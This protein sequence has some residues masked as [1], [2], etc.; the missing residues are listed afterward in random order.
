MAE[1]F[2]TWDPGI[3]EYLIE[4]GADVETGK[5]LA[6]ALSN[7]VRTALRIFKRY[8]DR[9]PS[10]QEQANIALRHHCKEG[11][12]KWVSLMLLAGADPYAPGTD[13][14][15]QKSGPPSESELSA[16]GYAALYGH[17]EVFDL[18]NVALDVKHPALQRIMHYANHAEVA[19]VVKRLFAMG[20][21][22]NDQENGGCSAIQSLL[23][24]MSWTFSLWPRLEH[25]PGRADTRESRQKMKAIH[26]LAKHGARWV[27]KDK[28][29]VSR[30]RRSLLKLKPDY[31]VEFVW[32]MSKYKACALDTIEE[33]L[34]PSSSLRPHLSH[35][36]QRI[37]ELLASWS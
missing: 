7:R 11:N 12:M 28:R 5:P 15:S 3:M 6:R 27:P 25:E 33:L 10:F 9:F 1:V 34:C 8:K 22:P 14:Y 16:L 31:A 30:A 18:K 20:M 29:Q 4:K 26:I 32:I 21:E 24:D 17:A 23:D 13:D 19:P 35:Y 37:D 2:D 36:S